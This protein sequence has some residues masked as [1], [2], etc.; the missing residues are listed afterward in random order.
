M[1]L[2]CA[3]GELRPCLLKTAAHLKQGLRMLR[4]ARRACA[5]WHACVCLGHLPT[6][7]VAA[8]APGCEATMVVVL[9]RTSHAWMVGLQSVLP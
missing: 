3:G 1:S 7:K 8:G 5:A 2:V 4:M 6:R 9:E